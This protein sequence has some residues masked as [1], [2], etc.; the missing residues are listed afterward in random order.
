MKKA[1]EDGYMPHL[2]K[3]LEIKN[4]NIL[5]KRTVL[6]SS[7]VI[8]QAKLFYGLSENILG[9]RWYI[10]KK[11]K[12][13]S[14]SF[15][16]LM[17][18]LE[19][20]IQMK[21]H[22]KFTRGVVFDSIFSGGSSNVSSLSMSANAKSEISIKK[23]LKKILEYSF[24]NK[25]A[26][27][28]NVIKHIFIETKEDFFGWLTINPK[29]RVK[30]KPILILARSFGT[31][32][33]PHYSISKI[34]DEIRKETHPI[35]WNWEGY[36][37]VAHRFGNKNKL[38]F[39]E[40][41]LMDGYITKLLIMANR[42]G[43]VVKLFSDHGQTYSKIFQ[44]LNKKR[45]EDILSEHLNLNKKL[46]AE[47]PDIYYSE[48]KNPKAR[49][50]ILDGGPTSL[51]YF[52]DFKHRLSENE[53]NKIY[54]GLIQRLISVNGIGMVAVKKNNKK[55]SYFGREK[56]PLHKYL[57]SSYEIKKL[58]K[59]AKMK[60]Q[61]D[62]ILFGDF[63]GKEVVCFEDQISTHAGLGGIQME[64]FEVVFYPY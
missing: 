10:K 45:L 49:I 23:S 61:A 29:Y 46:I 20:Q 59:W 13:I 50:I 16:D 64:R 6:P 24:V 53:I 36:D 48:D 44:R 18:E 37:M 26:L 33:L 31:G 21:K 39:N 27:A 38:T 58:E 32:I 15:G 28:L 55:I 43:Y 41:K 54:P 40:L 51:I 5:K 30:I 62:I 7:T 4:V 56:N 17:F 12:L 35:Y 1:L 11:D 14:A 42:K 19:G 2:K 52:R 9:Y 63:D 47:F 22:G 8:F 25:P 57:L 3:Y 34:F 60:N